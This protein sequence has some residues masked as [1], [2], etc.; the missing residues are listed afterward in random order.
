MKNGNNDLKEV[1]ARVLVPE[2]PLGLSVKISPSGRLE[3]DLTG[4]YK[5]QVNEP[6]KE[7]INE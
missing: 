3:V 2:P 5:P 4:Y 7:A 1:S 6:R